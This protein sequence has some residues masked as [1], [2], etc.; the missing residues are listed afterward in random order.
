MTRVLN[1]EI[2]LIVSILNFIFATIYMKS[3]KIVSQFCVLQHY[4]VVCG[5]HIS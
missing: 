3:C 1:R 2:I 4:N 5:T